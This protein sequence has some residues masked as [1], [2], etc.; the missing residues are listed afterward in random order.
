MNLCTNNS[1]RT[2][3]NT[4]T[5]TTTTTYTT[6]IK[7]NND[8]ITNIDMN[9]NINTNTNTNTTSKQPRMFLSSLPQPPPGS[10]TSWTPG[11]GLC[12]IFML[13]IYIFSGCW[14]YRCTKYYKCTID[15]Q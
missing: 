1:T 8:T 6:T 15:D 14:N 4:K 5:T 3:T 11:Q 9:T 7:T 2:N 12:Y 13:Y 10:V